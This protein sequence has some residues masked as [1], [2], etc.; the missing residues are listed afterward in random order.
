MKQF[1]EFMIT[2]TLKIINE[3]SPK[4]SDVGRPSLYNDEVY[5]RA[6]FKRLR[7]GVQWCE[8]ESEPHYSCVHKK[9][10]LWTYIGVFN[11]LWKDSLSFYSKVLGVQWNSLMVD[12]SYVKNVR[13][14]DLIGRNPTDRGRNSSKISALTDKRGVPLSVVFDCG[15]VHDSKLFQRTLDNI[16]I[17]KRKDKRR[18]KNMYV[19][20]GYSGVNCADQIKEFGYD[21][22]IPEKKKKGNQ[23]RNLHHRVE[24]IIAYDHE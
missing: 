1:P 3:L 4:D 9:Q 5:I 24:K 22:I 15:N 14:C 17:R 18:K 21:I 12:A 6:M 10:K 8:L 19:D 23:D 13:G 11:H 16:A 20:K 7:T 2:M